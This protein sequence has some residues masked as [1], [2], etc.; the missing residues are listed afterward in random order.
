V[1]IA[2]MFTMLLQAI[3]GTRS[4]DPMKQADRNTTR[5]DELRAMLV[6]YRQMTIEEAEETGA[7]DWE[8]EVQ[9]EV[10]RLEQELRDAKKLLPRVA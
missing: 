2:A 6:A 4:E 3:R 7:G 5:I 1:R 10:W 9:G 8:I